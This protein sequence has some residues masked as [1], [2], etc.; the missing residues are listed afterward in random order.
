MNSN[1]RS[2]RGDSEDAGLQNKHTC[3]CAFSL[4]R[5]SGIHELLAY[6]P[7]IRRASI[8][9]PARRVKSHPKTHLGLAVL[10]H[11]P[12]EG[13]KMLITCSPTAL[14]TVLG[15][16]RT[17]TAYQL[18]GGGAAAGEDCIPDDSPEP[19][20]PEA[21]VVEVTTS[22]VSGCRLFINSSMGMV[23]VGGVTGTGPVTL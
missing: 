5:D 1:T 13:C 2:D 17:P 10:F 23:G 11:A 14:S 15:N 3:T 20:D 22:G 19:P 8:T 6:Q 7:A 9:L 16:L 12:G 18:P 4:R 21:E